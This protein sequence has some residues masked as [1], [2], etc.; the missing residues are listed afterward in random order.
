MVNSQTDQIPLFDDV[1]N[2]YYDRILQ[3]VF[4]QVTNLEDAKDL[5][6]EIFIKVYNSYHTFK[7]EKGN[8]KTWIFAI[9]N[10][11][12]INFHKSAMQKNK[13]NLELNLDLIPSDTD[14]L[15][16]V[17]LEEDVLFIVTLMKRVLNNRNTR[18]LHLYFFSNLTTEE[19]AESMKMNQKTVSNIISLSIKKLRD[20]LEVMRYE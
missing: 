9:A 2:E 20:K 7:P 1:L 3:F 19:I 6:Q 10:N 11:H 12:I 17:I 4:K 5:T 16:S 8:I 18:I 14:I 15:E 13:A